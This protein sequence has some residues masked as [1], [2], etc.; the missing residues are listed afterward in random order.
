MDTD[1]HSMILVFPK[2]KGRQ[3]DEDR[4][5]AAVE[6]EVRIKSALLQSQELLNVEHMDFS[7]SPP[8]LC[9]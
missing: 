4:K 2:D 8:S 1:S 3:D 5:V 6:Y 7:L 9:N